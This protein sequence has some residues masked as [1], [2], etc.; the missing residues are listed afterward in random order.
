MINNWNLFST[1]TATPSG[2]D[3]NIQT[4][5]LRPEQ[6]FSW[7]AVGF[8]YASQIIS[9]P[10][11]RFYLYAC[12]QQSNTSAQDPFAIGVA[13]ADAVLG[14]YTDVTGAPIVSQ[15]F[16]SPGNN[17][18]NIDPTILVDDDGKVYMYWGTFGQLRGTE[19]DPSDMSITTVSSLT[20]FF[21]APWIM[22]RDGIYYM[23]Y[24]ANNA[25][26]DS[27]CTPTSYHACIAYGTAESPLGPWT[28]RGSLLGIVSS[29]TSH[30][31]AVEYKGQWYLIYHTASA[32][33][34]GNFRR[35]IAWDELDFDDAVSPP[36]IKLVAQ[37][38]RPL[39]PKEPTRNRAQLATATDEPECAIQY[40]LAALNDEK[41]NPVPLP[42]EIWSSYNGDNSPV[43]MSLTYTWNTTQTLNGVAMVF[44]ADQPAGSVTGVAPPVSWTVE[45]LTVDNTWQPVVN[46]TQYSLEAGGE[47]VEVGFDEVQT[48]SL[49]ALLRASIDGTQTA[50]VGVAEWYAY[51]PIEQ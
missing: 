5:F 33:Q 12:F 38:S 48:N 4:D 42:P 35:S 46:Q 6:V 41:I 51:A 23:L 8:A 49:R 30:S 31:G 28:F 45:Y 24:A 21:E 43:N 25:G 18:Q 44:F 13:V 2:G 50:G 34:G 16:P 1:S 9:G 37:T 22:K 3:W 47:A 26:R 15:T 27:P 10:D 20:G 32:D 19:L 39:P 17:I 7:A 14:P 36:A 29:T 40:W 11:S